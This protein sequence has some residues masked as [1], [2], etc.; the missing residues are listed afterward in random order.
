MTDGE[1]IDG[2]LNM[3]TNTRALPMM[4]SNIKGA[5][6]IQFAVTTVSKPLLG[7]ASLLLE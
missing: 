5:L 3:A 1:R 2:V 7:L 4:D 6:R